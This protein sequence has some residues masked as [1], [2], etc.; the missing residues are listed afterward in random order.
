MDSSFFLLQ[1]LIVHELNLGLI[2]IVTHPLP[3]IHP[4]NH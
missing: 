3:F 1:P 2:V 4:I